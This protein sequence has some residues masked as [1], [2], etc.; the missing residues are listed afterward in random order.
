MTTRFQSIQVGGSKGRDVWS[1]RNQF[2][3]WKRRHYLPR[4]GQEQGGSSCLLSTRNIS[5]R[6]LAAKKGYGLIVNA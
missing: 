5:A 3:G 4:I 6:Q 1:C 2:V